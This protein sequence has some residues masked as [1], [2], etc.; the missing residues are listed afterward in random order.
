MLV[1][2]FIF[3]LA[4]IQLVIACHFSVTIVVFDYLNMY[5]ALNEKNDKKSFRLEIV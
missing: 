1:F 4:V 5:I 2:T 3:E